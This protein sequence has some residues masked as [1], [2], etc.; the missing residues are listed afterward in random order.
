MDTLLPLA[1]GSIKALV[2]LV[3][4]FGITLALKQRAA[5]LRAVVWG[6]AIAGCLVIPL[7]APLLPAWTVPVPAALERYTSPT[8]PEVAVA[9]TLEPAHIDLAASHVHPAA[10]TSSPQMPAAPALLPVAGADAGRCPTRSRVNPWRRI[11]PGCG[12]AESQSGAR[13]HRRTRAGDG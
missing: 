9:V 4:A 3:L 1:L 10:S 5:R 12:G 11:G 7:V 8:E 13:G 6:T 2:L